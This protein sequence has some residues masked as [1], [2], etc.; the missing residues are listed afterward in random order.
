[1][2][3]FIVLL[4]AYLASV[5]LAG[6]SGKRNSDEVF[7]R[8]SK[9]LLLAI[10]VAGFIVF[11][12]A[13]AEG[14]HLFETFLKSWISMTCGGLATILIPLLFWALNT[15][16]KGLIRLIAGAQTSSIIIGWFGMQFPVLVKLKTSPSLTVYNTLAPYKTLQMMIIAL[17]VGLA[18]VIPLLLYLFKVFKFT[19]SKEKIN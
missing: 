2:G 7:V 4:F 1:M 15:Q 18:F 3:I 10:V 14:L 19:E 5:Y 17:L 16:K 13:E 6:E 9:K 8:Y 12:T 11:I